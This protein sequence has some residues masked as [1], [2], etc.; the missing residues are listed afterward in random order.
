M[1]L[2]FRTIV[3][4]AAIYRSIIPFRILYNFIPAF[5][6]V[7][8]LWALSCSN[9]WSHIY[10]FSYCKSSFW[11]TMYSYSGWDWWYG[12]IKS[13]RLIGWSSPGRSNNGE[14]LSFGEAEPA[15]EFSCKPLPV[16]VVDG[17]SGGHSHRRGPECSC[18][19]SLAVHRSETVCHSYCPRTVL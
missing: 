16:A 3:V 1:Y 5:A 2:C 6:K 13:C 10:S 4:K 15:L 14:V 9:M 17:K 18:F 7:C 12:L 8:T 11:L 19:V